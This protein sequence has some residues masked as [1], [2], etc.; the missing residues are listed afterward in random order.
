MEERELNKKASEKIPETFC[1][2]KLIV[3]FE[4]DLRIMR[5]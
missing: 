2:L 3:E 5:A 4:P 1:S